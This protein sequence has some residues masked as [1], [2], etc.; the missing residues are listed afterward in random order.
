MNTE[1]YNKLTKEIEQLSDKINKVLLENEKLRQ[2]SRGSE[3]LSALH[4]QIWNTFFGKN[5]NFNNWF[6]LNKL[7]ATNAIKACQTCLVNDVKVYKMD[8]T[9]EQEY[10]NA[11]KIGQNQQY[12]EK[13]LKGFD[14]EKQDQITNGLT[15]KPFHCIICKNHSFGLVSF[16]QGC[17]DVVCSTCCTYW[18]HQPN[19]AQ[20]TESEQELNQDIDNLIEK[21][22]ELKE[23]LDS[24]QKLD[25]EIVD[26]CETVFINVLKLLKRDRYTDESPIHFYNRAWE[27]FVPCLG[28]F[29]SMQKTY[30]ISQKDWES[31]VV[32]TKMNHIPIYVQ[33]Q[34]LQAVKDKEDFCKIVG[35]HC[36]ICKDFHNL[37]N[38]QM[39]VDCDMNVCQKCCF[40]RQ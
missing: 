6:D 30:E 39:C 2:Q 33:L 34:N 18:Y 19:L 9:Q 13:I 4:T 40:V 37:T 23:I 10:I 22:K 5:Q 17:G 38:D 25:K 11:I 15:S 1:I 29:E 32:Y 3:K 8:K 20:K 36:Y 7:I 14:Q 12:L 35:N 27:T 26:K 16:C 31:I 28:C 21:L 24:E